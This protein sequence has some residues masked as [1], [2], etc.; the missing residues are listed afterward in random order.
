MEESFV[1]YFSRFSSCCLC[2]S[3]VVLVSFWGLLYSLCQGF[4]PGRHRQAP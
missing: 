1:E 3:D 4:V 2:L